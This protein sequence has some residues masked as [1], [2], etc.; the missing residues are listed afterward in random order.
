VPKSIGVRAF[1]APANPGIIMYQMVP[2]S[3]NKLVA[4]QG[5]IG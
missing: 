1:I 4:L 2:P 3:P 5:R